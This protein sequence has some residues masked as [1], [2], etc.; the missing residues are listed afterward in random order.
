[1]KANRVI[2]LDTLRLFA[3]LFVFVGHGAIPHIE[4]S[5]YT[6]E[7]LHDSYSLLIRIINF[8]NEYLIGGNGNN[9]VVLFFVISGFCIHYPYAQGKEFKLSE[10]YIRRFIRICLPM[11]V[12]I[13]IARSIGY[14]TGTEDYLNGIPAWSL[15][16]EL[17]YYFFYPFFRLVFKRVSVFHFLIFCFLI[18]MSISFLKIDTTDYACL[19]YYGSDRNFIKGIEVWPLGDWVIGLAPW[20]LGVLLANN[21]K[22]ITDNTNTVDRS[23]IWFVRVFGVLLAAIFH[24]VYRYGIPTH[25]TAN[26]LSIYFYFW[27]SNEFK[28]MRTGKLNS[29]F[30]WGG[31]WSYSLYLIHP[32]V[33]FIVRGFEYTSYAA[34]IATNLVIGIA[35]SIIFYYIVEGPSHQLAFRLSKKVNSI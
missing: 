18:S 17:F 10:F 23:K 12:A 21:Y 28:Y 9:A 14:A 30:E 35:G 2:G 26:F 15:V 27:L 22:K 1:M 31:K 20:M 24:Q 29:M 32:S 16:A 25:L 34:I 3:A 6:G 4:T 33:L 8:L 5:Y 19:G 7:I 11:A 13:G